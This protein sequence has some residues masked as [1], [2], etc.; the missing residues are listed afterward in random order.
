[1]NPE[2]PEVRKLIKDVG[3]IKAALLGDALTG[4]LGLMNNHDKIMLDMYGIDPTGAE[5]RS[6]K[7]TLLKRLSSVEDFQKKFIW[8]VGGIIFVLTASRL[9]FGAVIDLIYKK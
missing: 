7:N 2:H 9:G 5:V 8:V 3:E 1:M 4:K 6:K